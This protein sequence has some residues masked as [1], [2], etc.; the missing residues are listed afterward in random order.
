M[1]KVIRLTEQDL[2]KMIKKSLAN[3]MNEDVLGDNW[4]EREDDDVLNNYEPFE[5]QEGDDLDS[6]DWGVSGEDNIDPTEYD[7]DD[8]DQDEFG[9]DEYDDDYEDHFVEAGSEDCTLQ[10][11]VLDGDNLKVTITEFGEDK[12]LI[13][14]KQ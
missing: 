1:V 2:S 4:Q 6:H 7:S 12:E 11:V 10:S 5:D 8:Y 14:V 9:Y 13:F 3:I